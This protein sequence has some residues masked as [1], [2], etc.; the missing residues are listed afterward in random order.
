MLNSMAIY[1]S[2]FYVL[3]MAK[4]FTPS[5]KFVHYK[6]IENNLDIIF[7]SFFFVLFNQIV[8]FIFN[9][10][11]DIRYLILFGLFCVLNS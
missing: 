8:I 3:L 5:K 1:L 4:E 7:K 2:E 11:N 10:I 6:R 9:D